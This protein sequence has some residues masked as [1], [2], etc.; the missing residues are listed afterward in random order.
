MVI[1]YRRTSDPEREENLEITLNYLSSIGIT[2]LVISEYSAHSNRNF[3]FKEYSDMFESFQAIHTPT[4][5]NEPFNLSR[6]L[7][8]GI[9]QA[10]TPFIATSDMD[11]MTRKENVDTCLAL[12]ESGYDVVHP[13]N[14]RITQI[15]DKEKFREDFDFSRV[16][17]PEQR[18]KTADGGVVF[19]NK[20]S[21]VSIGMLNEYFLGWGGEDNEVMHRVRICGLK[22]Y[23]IDDTLYHLYH[24]QPQYRSRNNVKV[25]AKSRQIK[26]KKECLEQVSKWPWVIEAKKKFS[27]EK[28]SH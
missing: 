14:R 4:A 23:R 18:R 12:L 20:H 9:L 17:T 27:T 11:C 24:Q 15:V 19:W 13:F 7:N 16:K 8:R 6:A 26:T 3:L 1:P 25:E 21:F 28:Y 10:D 2:N 22:H 5:Q